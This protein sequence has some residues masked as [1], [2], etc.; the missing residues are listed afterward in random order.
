MARL[1]ALITGS[2]AAIWAPMAM[3]MPPAVA[4]AIVAGLG[5]GA[6][7]ASAGIAVAGLT[8]ATTAIAIGVA[9]AGLTY[10]S[11]TQ[12][13]KEAKAL[14]AQSGNLGSRAANR[15]EMIRQS[16]A[17]RRVIYGQA[18]VSGPIAFI[19]T[20]NDDETLHIVLLI[21]SHEVESF[22]NFYIADE[23]VELNGDPTTGFRK[24]SGGEYDG[25]VRIR[26]FTGKDDQG[27]SQDLLSAVP[28]LWS[29]SHRLRGIAY[30]YVR[31][32][33]D[34][35]VFTSGI[36]P[37]RCD[38]KGKKIADPRDGSTGW[39]DNS[40]LILRDYLLADPLGLGAD[41]SEIDEESFE[42]AANLADEIVTIK[43][44]SATIAGFSNGRLR[45]E[46]ESMYLR[47]GDRV[48]ITSTGSMPGGVTSGQ[49][50]FAVGFGTEQFKLATSLDAARAG[51][52]VGIS[53]DGSGTVTV[54]RDGEPR[55][56]INGVIL[57]DESR[58]S[59]L[60]RMQL[61]Q[62][63]QMFYSGGKFGIIPASYTT[64]TIEFDEDDLT[65]TINVSP[66]VSR[67][68]RF[69]VV[70]GTFI[71]AE[72]NWEASDYPAIKSDAFI[73]LDGDEITEELE[74]DMTISPS[75]AQR[76]AKIS[77]LEMRQELTVSVPMKLTGLT[78][79]VGDI[80]YFS[81]ETFGFNR[82][83]LSVASVTASTDEI[84]FTADHDLKTGDILKF[85]STGDLP[86]GLN[87]GQEYRAIIVN[88]T[89]V[90]VAD[91]F[92]DAIE[93]NE[94][95]ITDSG[96]GTVTAEQP[97][98]AFRVVAFSF[99]TG[100][101]S[102][103]MTLGT[104]LQLKEVD[105][106]V[107]DFDTDEEVTIDPSRNTT[108]PS[109][110]NQTAPPSNLQLFSGTEQLGVAGDGTV[111][112][113]IEAR[114]DHPN[115][116]FARFYEIE[117]R[118][119]TEDDF[120]TT[121]IGAD[122]KDY[123]ISPVEDGKR[124]DVRV[125]AINALGIPSA[126]INRNS[127]RVIG[128]T[129]PPPTPDGFDVVRLPDGTRRY[130]FSTAN[131]PA[132]VRTGGGVLIKFSTDI[133]AAWE[134]MT[135]IRDVFRASPLELNVPGQG[136]FLFAIKMVDSAGNESETARF[137][138]AT[139]GEPRISDVIF[140]RVEEDELWPGTITNGYLTTQNTLESTGAGDWTDLPNTWD[141]L[142]DEWRKIVTTNDPLIYETPVIDLGDEFA[143]TPLVALTGDG[144]PT[145]TFKTGTEVDG[146]VT[147]SFRTLEEVSEVRYVQ[148]R[149][150]MAGQ[151]SFLTSLAYTLDGELVDQDY[152]DVDT[153]S[154]SNPNF[155]RIGAGHF[156]IGMS[157]G[158]ARI[159]TAQISSI[160]GTGGTALFF[161]LVSKTEVVNGNPAA[162]FKL[163]DANGTLTDA[164]VDIFLKGPKA[165]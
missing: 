145:N 138:T 125:R 116:A 131:F 158:A 156:Q 31:M 29:Q 54:T 153:S 14:A 165:T 127:Y 82:R 9:T 63:A 113:R 149:I 69:N 42:A 94:V 24:V 18:R 55:F 143:F 123:Y 70:K 23:P 146:T 21:A 120:T 148:F 86:N 37:V 2:V 65:G 11:T 35:E 77:L 30:L 41:E 95:D 152:T 19:H 102:D 111:I 79:R 68:D 151:G 147:G 53:S 25:K 64:P 3:A 28:N 27:V 60:S 101:D 124:Y 100:Q 73:E 117:Y 128:K 136:T 6:A 50:Y 56:A 34:S 164:T 17:S 150:S 114:W 162:E 118:R 43:E 119:S 74:L 109:P 49:T 4:G 75:M 121:I 159:A 33:F 52:N 92:Q 57:A 67:R 96:T 76:V 135:Q 72:N 105:S 98:K 99:T 137:L 84:A 61:A 122:S 108:L 7:V 129:E 10:Y 91:T 155:N 8:V 13:M 132:D 130:S 142:D 45:V 112:S 126:F 81:N 36:P 139:L 40:A 78:V 103:V 62:G 83:N 5:T 26:A 134:N 90:Q 47:T 110:L 58:K 66:K 87:A 133:N 51:G 1:I 15:K 32:Q 93:S 140:F 161:N 46:E 38:V 157:T 106:S 115:P 48:R 59:V 97:P 104:N 163:F 144:T 88:D 141:A 107:Y 89:T 80:V 12:A 154:F 39:T 160:Q 44:K 16:I 71:A 85:E 20:T 22:D